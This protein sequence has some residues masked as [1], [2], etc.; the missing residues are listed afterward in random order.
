[1]RVLRSVGRLRLLVAAAAIVVT[2][3]V[4]GQLRSSEGLEDTAGRLRPKAGQ[5]NPSLLSRNFKVRPVG[6]LC[7][8]VLSTEF[9]RVCFRFDLAEYIMYIS[10]VYCTECACTDLK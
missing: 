1:M 10:C 4:V 8:F 5:A 3:Y 7:C 9:L 2:V 6:F